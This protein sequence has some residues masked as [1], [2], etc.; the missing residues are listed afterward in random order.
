MQVEVV[1]VT[2]GALVMAMVAPVSMFVPMVVV[3]RRTEDERRHDIDQKADGGDGDGFLVADELRRC[4]SLHR[5]NEHQRDDHQEED[6]TGE[7]AQHLNLPGAKGESPVVR[8]FAC[9]GIGEGAQPDGHGMRAHVEAVRQQRHR[10]VEPA[11]SNFG[12]HH[13][14]RNSH[15]QPSAALAGDVPRVEDVVVAPLG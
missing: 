2:M 5:A 10:V 13:G 4:Q 1:V 15:H 9:S 8:V 7:S 3:V 14:G 12:H 11:G 6:G